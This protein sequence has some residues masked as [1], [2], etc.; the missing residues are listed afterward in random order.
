[1]ISQETISSLTDDEL[2][3]VLYIVNKI[4]T[5]GIKISPQ[6]LKSYKY[7]NLA[8]HVYNSR[9]KIKDDYFPIY[10]GLCNKLKIPCP[11]LDNP[12][13]DDKKK[14]KELEAKNA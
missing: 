13:T 3:M 7:K 5:C 1:M 9:P 2:A 12:T 11:D 8:T 14:P 4:Y 6:L 10:Q